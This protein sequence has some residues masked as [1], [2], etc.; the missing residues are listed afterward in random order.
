MVNVW[1]EI[2]FVPEVVIPVIPA[3]TAANQL[4]VAPT[5]LLVRLTADVCEPEQ[6]IWFP[7][8]KFTA[9]VGLTVMVNDFELPVQPFAVGV[10]VMVATTGIVPGF[11]PVN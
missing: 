4:S 8:E 6:T 3:G 10:T 7:V 1:I 5:T 11:T 2:W 9:G